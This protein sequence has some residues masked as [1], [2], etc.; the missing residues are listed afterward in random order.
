MSE[1]LHLSPAGQDILRRFALYCLY[2]LSDGGS[3]SWFNV[4]DLSMILGR[5][6]EDLCSILLGLQDRE[7]VLL[8]PEKEFVMIRSL[9]ACFV[10][11]AL[12]G[13]SPS[14]FS[15]VPI[16][17]AGLLHDE[18]LTSMRQR[19]MEKKSLHLFFLI[20]LAEATGH[21]LDHP[22]PIGHAV[23]S[24]R[25]SGRS[26]LRMVRTLA[27]DGMVQMHNSDTWVTPTAD[28]LTVAH[29]AQR[30]PSNPSPE[31]F[32]YPSLLDC[33]ATLTRMWGTGWDHI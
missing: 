8:D 14:S 10:E 5:S 13:R 2:K 12:M 9:G 16:V 7:L 22:I 21:R 19:L 32:V 28:G 20:Q 18:D 31:P 30:H 33:H 26:L 25:G 11:R 6:P 27:V 17:D 1:Y 15:P 24:M 4:A 29:C 3:D 23:E